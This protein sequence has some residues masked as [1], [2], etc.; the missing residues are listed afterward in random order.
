[1]RTGE[2]AFR[3]SAPGC[4]SSPSFREVSWSPDGRYVAT[5]SE[6]AT[7][8]WDAETGSLVHTLFGQTGFV[9]AV[10][11]SPDSSRLVTGG[12]DGTAKVWE[13]RQT[14]VRELW[15]LPAQETNSWILGVAFSP[16]GTRVMAGDGG[17]SVVKIWDLGPTGDAEWANLP[18][19]DAFQ[20]EFMPDGRRLVTSRMFARA[21][22]IWDLQTG[23]EVR[24]IGPAN[25]HFWFGTFDVSPDGGSI[26]LG[27]GSKREGFGGASAVRAWDTSTEEEL[28]RIGHELDVNEVAF[29]PDGEYLVTASWDDTG[30]VLDRTGR[31]LRVLRERGFSLHQARFSPDGRLV[32]TVADSDDSGRVRVTIWDWER[33]EIVRTFSDAYGVAFDP[34]APR[35]AMVG[36]KGLVEVRDVESGSRV[37]VLQGPSGGAIGVAFSPDG[38]RVAVPHTDGTV[39]LFETATGAQQL[40]LPGFGCTVSRVAFSP[41]GTKLASASPCG[42]LRVWALDID[43]LLEIARR[44]VP[45]TL[46]DQECR[47]YLHMDHC[48]QGR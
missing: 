40:V 42:G 48:R 17:N 11:W 37:A 32:A 18:A 12:S 20:V 43:D 39:R 35:I 24:T 5:G 28:W 27:G 13:I 36:P 46:T 15:S 14:G 6:D 33:D 45:R 7:H 4:C 29:S 3:L 30:K 31:V 34:S 19:P 8:V 16:D 41:D 22:T 1:V 47:Q 38:S 44:E 10:A 26:A 23:R 9:R 25:D 21:V 2:E